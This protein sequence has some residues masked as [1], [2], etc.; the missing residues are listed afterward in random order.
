MD[1]KRL[2]S[3]VLK[4]QNVLTIDSTKSGVVAYSAKQ[5]NGDVC[6]CVCQP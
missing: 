1:V 4:I 2:R 3:H 6:V 5:N